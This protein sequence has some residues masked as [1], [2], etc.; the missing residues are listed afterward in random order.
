[1]TAVMLR[2]LHVVEENGPLLQLNVEAPVMEDREGALG[3][4]TL[5]D[6][7]VPTGGVVRMRGPVVL[8]ELLPRDILP[9]PPPLLV[10]LGLNL[11]DCCLYQ[12]RIGISCSRSVSIPLGEWLLML[13]LQLRFHTGMTPMGTGP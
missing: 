4:L 8:L 9:H 10:L 5:I 3:P 12:W 13:R 6:P 11:G 7:Q 2:V 1:M